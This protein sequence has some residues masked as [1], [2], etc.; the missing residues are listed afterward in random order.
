ME[1]E[2]WITYLND[3]DVRFRGVWSYITSDKNIIISRPSIPDGTVLN[4]FTSKILGGI[5]EATYTNYNN[6]SYRCYRCAYRSI[7]HDDLTPETK[8]L[9]E[10][11][12]GPCNGVIF[13]IE[14]EL[15]P[16]E[17]LH[18]CLKEVQE[19]PGFTDEVKYGMMKML[20]LA[21]YEKYKRET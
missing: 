10:E 13:S 14:T 9:I 18:E 17:E 5:V 12:A 2:E 7:C 11:E 20:I 4:I 3:E 8:R 21:E 6:D 15:Y 16:V 19:A 1:P